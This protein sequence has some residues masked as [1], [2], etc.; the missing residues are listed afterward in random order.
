MRTRL[1]THKTMPHPAASYDTFEDA[2]SDTASGRSLEEWRSYNYSSTTSDMRI[3]THNHP[4][5]QVNTHMQLCLLLPPPPHS[6]PDDTFEDAVSDTASGRS[7]EERRSSQPSSIGTDGLVI[8]RQESENSTRK[9]G[10]GR[11]FNVKMD[12]SSPRD[13]RESTPQV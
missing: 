11:L 7:Q 2:D 1:H 9:K 6:P 3:R 13:S 8:S 10:L 5:T 12:R 4:H